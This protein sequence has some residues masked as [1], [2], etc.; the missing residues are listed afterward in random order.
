MGQ[1]QQSTIAQ[2]ISRQIENIEKELSK[3][4]EWPSDPKEVEALIKKHKRKV[5]SAVDIE[6]A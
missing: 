1:T 6:F 5:G 4:I 2:E 3:K